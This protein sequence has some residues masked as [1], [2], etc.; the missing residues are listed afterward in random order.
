MNGIRS[1]EDYIIYFFLSYLIPY[2]Y[3]LLTKPKCSAMNFVWNGN[4]VVKPI[5]ILIVLSVSMVLMGTR[6][7]SL[8]IDKTHLQ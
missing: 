3:S 7:F 5:Y 8:F 1:Y 4:V 6:R 2:R